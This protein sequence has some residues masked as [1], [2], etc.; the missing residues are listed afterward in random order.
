VVAAAAL[1]LLAALVPCRTA[2]QVPARLEAVEWMEDAGG[3]LGPEAVAALPVEAFR[4]LLV[5]A[6]A[7]F[8]LAP[9]WIRFTAVNAT[10]R[11]AEVDLVFRFPMMEQLDLWQPGQEG[12]ARLRGGLAVPETE[13]QIRFEDGCHLVR[14]ALAPHERR[15]GLLRAQT[16]GAGF[17]GLELL[18]ADDHRGRSMVSQLALAELGA[19]L[20]LLLLHARHALKRRRTTDLAALGFLAFQLGHLLIA[21]G[22]LST[23]WAL[24]PGPLLLAKSFIAGLSS[25]A[26]CF[27]LAGYLGTRR[28]RPALHAALALCGWASLL[29]S[30]LALLW[31]TGGG[32][33]VS[34]LGLAAMLV[35]VVATGEALLSGQRTIRLFLP[36]LTVFCV[37]TT[38]YLLSLLGLARPSPLVVLAEILGALSIAAS[39]LA[40]FVQGDWWEA[41]ARRDH[42]GRQVAERTATLARTEVALRAEEAERRRAEERFRLAFETNPDAVSITRAVD[43]VVLAANPGFQRLYGLGLEEVLGRPIAE[44]GLWDGGGR[45]A[46]M[47][48]L[49]QEGAVR[50]VEVWARLRS[51]ERRL[52]LLSASVLTQAGEVL[53]L[54]AARDVTDLRAT[55]VARARLEDDLRQAQKLEAIGRLAA[56]VAHDFNNLLAVLSADVSLALEDLPAEA[57]TRAL[58]LDAQQTVQRATGLTRQLLSFTRRRT[59]SRQPVA[60]GELVRG[61]DRLFRRLVGDQVALSMRVPEALPVVDADPGQLE[62]V[63][64]NLV[65][66]ARDAVKPGGQVLIE[67]AVVALP[68]GD[69]RPGGPHLRLAVQDDGAGMDEQTR[70]HIF[71]PF[72]T[73]KA[74]GKGT[75]LGLATVY[76][77]VQ[78]HGGFVSVRSAP[79]RGSTFEVFLPVAQA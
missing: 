53:V 59:G 17:L 1:C 77:V 44:L 23:F 79:G 6:A 40:A 47:A 24:P 60:V 22:T 63:F 65:V 2:A 78:Q 35:S 26:G 37:A 19:L 30:P 11:A 28:R 18:R 14:L 21:S 38:W 9:R 56:G 74:E 48:R 76:G 61:M 67:A 33:L 57:S 46:T 15:R 52:M 7:G 49:R 10:D 32:V 31:A 4:P 34:V 42:L 12:F 75:G 50:D 8:S 71:E 20:A 68:G 55:E 62:Q 16:S 13:R 27:F 5:T 3:S 29:A 51:G 66:N 69:G 36:G 54:A 73:T 64:L 70:Q 41:D 43:G 39:M 45:E 58:L 25:F 72:F